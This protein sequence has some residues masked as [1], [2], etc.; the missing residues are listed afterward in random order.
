[1]Q[2]SPFVLAI[3]AVSAEF[4]QRIFL[5][6]VGIVGGALVVL[7][8]LSI[9]LVTLS[10]WWWFILAPL[11]L[12][13]LFATFA[14]VIAGLVIRI[15]NPPQTK[16]QRTH[17]RSFVDSLQFASD[18]VQTPKFILFFR[19]VMNML[20]PSKKGIVNEL[21]H[22]AASLQRDFRAIIALFSE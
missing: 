2:N 16:Q 11:I 6:I 1:M 14:T 20:Q 22:N 3:R 13:C 4:A 5:P 19:L 8:A 9:W 17:V 12:I 15:L 7:I 10:G 21:S 18:T